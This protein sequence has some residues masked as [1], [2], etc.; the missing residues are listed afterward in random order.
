MFDDLTL[1][2]LVDSLKISGHLAYPDVLKIG[3]ERPGVILLDLGCC[4]E[5]HNT[6][7]S[8]TD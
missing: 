7:I 1:K 6:I 5:L 4:C 3:K 2:I 8:D